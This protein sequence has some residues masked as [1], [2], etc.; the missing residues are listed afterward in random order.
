MVSMVIIGGILSAV[1][2]VDGAAAISVGDGVMIMSPLVTGSGASGSVKVLLEF[3]GQRGMVIIKG[4][5][6][7]RVLGNSAAMFL[8]GADAMKKSPLLSEPRIDSVTVLTAYVF[9]GVSTAP[10]VRLVGTV[11]RNPRVATVVLEMIGRLEVISGA[12]VLASRGDVR[13]TPSEVSR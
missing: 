3:I 12:M 10:S 13:P 5:P 11:G 9:Q 1:L 6:S 8:V 7:T 2:L 4:E